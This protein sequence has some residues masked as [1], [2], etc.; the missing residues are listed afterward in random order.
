MGRVHSEA[1]DEASTKGMMDDVLRD[2]DWTETA[3]LTSA[4]EEEVM[5]VKQQKTKTTT[6]K[7]TPD[8][9]AR[10]PPVPSL[11]KGIE[12]AKTSFANWI[13]ARRHSV[14]SST[15]SRPRSSAHE[16]DPWLP[17]DASDKVIQSVIA[18][19]G[20]TAY[21]RA[22]SHLDPQEF[23]TVFAKHAKFAGRV[24]HELTRS[25]PFRVTSSFDVHEADAL[26]QELSGDQEGIWGE[27]QAWRRDET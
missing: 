3:T 6:T 17:K 12:S 20:P 27:N 14:A 19:M 26:L 22:L 21:D 7:Q 24:Y 8:E 23:E 18:S 5:V 2:G 11:V 13:K 16:R 25:L 10:S 15:S 1:T 4:F 9:P